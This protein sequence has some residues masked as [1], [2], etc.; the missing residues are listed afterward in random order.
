MVDEKVVEGSQFRMKTYRS[1][2]REVPNGESFEGTGRV[3]T[4]RDVSLMPR[5]SASVGRTVSLG[6]YEFARFTVSMS[7]SIEEEAKRKEALDALLLVVKEIVDREEAAIRGSS[8]KAVKVSWN[9][10]GSYA[11]MVSVDYGLT[12][13]A[14]IKMEFNKIDIGLNE[15][16]GDDEDMDEAVARVQEW[17]GQRML[18]ERAKLQ[19]PEMTSDMGI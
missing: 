6:D 12:L 7:V 14:K 3:A 10:A 13:K 4:Q 15:P 11:R 1:G 19:G 16:I 17:V 8:R 2:G 18:E 9:M 5:V